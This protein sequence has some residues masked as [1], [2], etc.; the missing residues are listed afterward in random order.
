MRKIKLIALGLGLSAIAS[1]CTIGHSMQ[2]TD[3]NVGSK[4]GVAKTKLFA[5]NN[6]ITVM[7]AAKNGNITK[8]ATV[9]VKTKVYLIFAITTTTV[10]GE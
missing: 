4:V 5:P 9:D 7:S 2:I 10:T 1:S 3:N 6:D 8:I